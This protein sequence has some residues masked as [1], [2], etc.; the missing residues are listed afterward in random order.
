MEM[1]SAGTFK[2]VGPRRL[3]PFRGLFPQGQ[4]ETR[5]APPYDV[6]DPDEAERLR[7]LDPHNV[8]HL[9]LPVAV[10]DA[11]SFETSAA[12][13]GAD[14]HNADATT[15]AAHRNAARLL[16]AWIDEGRLVAEQEPSLY[17]YRQTYVTPF[18]P[19]ETTG[20][21]GALL[22]GASGV[23]PHEET[24]KKAKSD[25]L[26]SLQETETNLSMIYALSPA[27][28]LC[29][30]TEPE[31]EPLLAVKDDQDVTHTIWSLADAARIEQ[32]TQ[33]LDTAPIIIADGHHRYSVA[34]T[35]VDDLGES[36]PAG[37]DRI[38]AFVVPLDPATLE[39]RPIHRVLPSLGIPEKDVPN[40]LAALGDVQS[41]PLATVD[42]DAI[43]DKIGLV[44]GGTLYWIS[45]RLRKQDHDTLLSD[46]PVLRDLAVTWVHKIFV[47]ALGAD[48][49][50]F[51]H[52]AAVVVERV[53]AGEAEAAVLLPPITVDDIARVADAGERMPPK[54]TFFWPK[55]RTG[56]VLRRF[57][58][59][60]GL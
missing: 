19:H 26:V 54:T 34:S 3:A 41:V 45:P 39:V 58:D 6:I 15:L 21:V 50:V 13:A 49:A 2:Y 14:A 59:Q 35:Y 33:L 47:P 4:I 36:A 11:R 1:T 29:E 43:P 5:T 24:T 12:V 18:G 28:R 8:I 51:H 22:L 40:T 52:S 48:E 44:I 30:L 17:V 10:G 7:S 53:V 55:A 38:M 27:P 32:M 37:A 56:L 42:L 60:A 16:T 9:D 25:R 57:A 31:G 23:L 20:V 46:P